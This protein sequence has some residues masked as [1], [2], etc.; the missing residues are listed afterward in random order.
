MEVERRDKR[1]RKYKQVLRQFV[2]WLSPPAVYLVSERLESINKVSRHKEFL[3]M[4]RDPRKTS[5]K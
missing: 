1:K 2:F 3:V 4:K 5:R